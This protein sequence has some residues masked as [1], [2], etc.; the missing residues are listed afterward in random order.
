MYMTRLDQYCDRSES[1]AELALLSEPPPGHAPDRSV[2][3]TGASG[4]IEQAIEHLRS[5]A[6]Q[7]ECGDDARHAIIEAW[8]A[9]EPHLAED[10]HD[11]LFDRVIDR[12]FP[13]S[14]T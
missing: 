13:K 6:R 14:A 2:R 3:R 9:V 5:L 12:V 4:Q 8:I 7:K 11:D 1:D 10:E